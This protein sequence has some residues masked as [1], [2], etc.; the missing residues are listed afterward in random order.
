MLQKLSESEEQELAVVT[1]LRRLSR[2]VWPAAFQDL[3]SHLTCGLLRSD[4][5]E[6][7]LERLKNTRNA[8]TLQM[9]ISPELREKYFEITNADLVNLTTTTGHKLT[10]S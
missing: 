6:W 5:D 2:P 3:T 1:V 10:A 7:P 9:N 8:R 4:S